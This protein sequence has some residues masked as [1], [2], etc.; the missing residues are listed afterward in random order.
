[1]MPPQKTS[2]NGN[3]YRPIRRY[4][5]CISRFH[6]IQTVNLETERHFGSYRLDKGGSHGLA[7]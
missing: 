1:M 4:M 3:K 2:Y 5:S 7:I 6:A